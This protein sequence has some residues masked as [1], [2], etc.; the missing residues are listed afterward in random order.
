[1]ICSKENLAS[2]H[3][4]KGYNHV[5]TVENFFKGFVHDRNEISA[6]PA[7]QYAERFVEFLDENII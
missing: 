2:A 3:K 7:Q 1:M 6:V 4:E 5:K